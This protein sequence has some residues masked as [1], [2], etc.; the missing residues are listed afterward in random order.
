MV[1]TTIFDV[2]P[3]I[4]GDDSQFFLTLFFL[5]GLFR[6]NGAT[7]TPNSSLCLMRM[8]AL[9]NIGKQCE[10]RSFSDC[11]EGSKRSPSCHPFFFASEKGQLRVENSVFF[12]FPWPSCHVCC[13]SFGVILRD[14]VCTVYAYIY[15]HHISLPLCLKRFYMIQKKG[16][17]L[18]NL[19][20]A[21]RDRARILPPATVDMG[22]WK[23]C[24]LSFDFGSLCHSQKGHQNCQEM[25]ILIVGFLRVRG[26]E[27]RGGGSREDWGTLGN[28]RED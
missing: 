15:T 13:E 22:A 19:R 5:P 8:W 9:R 27:P 11:L 24:H 26:V 18:M 1:V 25:L 16:Y 12:F 4:C 21:F 14:D 6:K 20:P 17:F 28:I 7:P 3:K 23:P 2:H 10:V